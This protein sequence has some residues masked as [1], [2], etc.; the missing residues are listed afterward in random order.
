MGIGVEMNALQWSWMVFNCGAWGYATV[1][2]HSYIQVLQIF[3]LFTTKCVNSA[4]RYHCRQTFYND[5]HHGAS[6]G[7]VYWC[8]TIA[9][10]MFISLIISYV[11]GMGRFVL[12]AAVALSLTGMTAFCFVSAGA[13]VCRISKES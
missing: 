10:S 9:L 12:G 13:R 6:V 2:F 8:Y 4:D 3:A 1:T 11:C 7:I 5:A